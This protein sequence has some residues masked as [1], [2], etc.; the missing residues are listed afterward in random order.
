MGRGGFCLACHKPFDEVHPMDFM[1]DWTCREM[2][3]DVP[4]APRYALGELYP[5]SSYQGLSYRPCRRDHTWR[6]H[7]QQSYTDRGQI[8]INPHIRVVELPK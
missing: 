6:E 3:S 1:N 7:V 5:I 4:V 2:C 8:W